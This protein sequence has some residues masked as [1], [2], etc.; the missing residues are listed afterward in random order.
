M[1]GLT[2]QGICFDSVYH[3]TMITL[4]LQWMNWTCT[5]PQVWAHCVVTLSFSTQS[6]ET[7]AVWEVTLWGEVTWPLLGVLEAL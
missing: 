6:D 5:L 2:L 4:S 3:C 7:I 1:V